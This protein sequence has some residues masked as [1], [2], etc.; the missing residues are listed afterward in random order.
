M[1][2][3]R[4]HER[5][6]YVSYKSSNHSYVWDQ[7]QREGGELCLKVY[8]WDAYLMLIIVDKK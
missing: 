6:N 8:E 4:S 7:L 2:E 3:N 5:D 1:N